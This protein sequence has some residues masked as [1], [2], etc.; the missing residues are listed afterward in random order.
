LTA[1]HKRRLRATHHAIAA[2]M[3]SAALASVA[4]KYHVPFIAI[5]AIS[6][7]LE[8]DLPDCVN[9]SMD[10]EGQVQPL[11]VLGHVAW[12]PA[13]WRALLQLGCGFRSAQKTLENVVRHT[14][15]T[16]LGPTTIKHT[17]NVADISKIE[18]GINAKGIQ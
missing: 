15:P 5:R 6:D 17:P 8:L 7:H 2:D 3:E 14:G 9:K 16:L 10:K 18:Y 13:Q 4:K 1:E 12:H 11:R